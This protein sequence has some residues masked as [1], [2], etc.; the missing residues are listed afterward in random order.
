MADKKDE[1]IEIKECP[2]NIH[3]RHTFGETNLKKYCPVF[4]DEDFLYGDYYEG[5]NSWL[6]LALH[7]CDEKKRA[8]YKEGCAKTSEIHEYFK[9][10]VI[11]VDL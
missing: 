8:K 5:K 3:G 6:R 2:K 9:K 10:K 4:K 11:A 1:I 7:K